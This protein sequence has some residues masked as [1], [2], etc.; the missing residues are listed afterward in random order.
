MPDSVTIGRALETG[1]DLALGDIERRSGLYVLGK[2]GM[3]K[4]TLLINLILK[5]IAH[6]HGVFFLGPHGD[7]VDDIL[8]RSD[9]PRV[10]TDVV[11]LDP[12]HATH[13][14]S[15]NLLACKDIA[16]WR[17]REDTYARARAVFWKL[18]ET[19][20]Q[21]TWLP[22]VLQNTLYAFIESPGYSLADVPEFLDNP[23]FRSRIL[24]NVQYNRVAADFFRKDFHPRQAQPLRDRLSLLLGHLPVRHIVGQ[25]TTTV[26]LAK[27]IEERKILLIKLSAQLPPDQKR[28]IGMILVSELLQAVRARGALPPAQRHQFSI[29]VDEFQNFVSSEDFAALINEGRKFAVA[30]TIAH[31]ERYGQ[32]ADNRALLGATATAANKVYFQLSGED[33][34]EV[35]L[36]FAKPPPTETRLEP[37]LV[38]SQN[39]ISELLRGHANPQIRGFVTRYLRPL[40]ERPEDIKADMEEQRLLRDDQRDLAAMDRVEAQM[41]ALR[42][43]GNP[44]P[45]LQRV[46]SA[47][48]FA[49]AQTAQLLSLQRSATELRSVTRGL[50]RFLTAIM[51]GSL[52]QGQEPFSD[53]LIGI[54]RV[55]EFSL[56]PPPS[57]EVLALYIAISYGHSK[58]PRAIPFAFA[59][60]YG[61]FQ[62]VAAQ[63]MEQAETQRQKKE[64]ER[65]KMFL[66]RWEEDKDVRASI[67]RS[68]V[69]DL[70]PKLM[71]YR[72][73]FDWWS[74]DLENV[75]LN[76]TLLPLSKPLIIL[77][78][79]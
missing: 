43:G 64:D 29:F 47:L 27:L 57:A 23:E 9:S 17:E 54:T 66:A 45:A 1:H 26:D 62:A 37:Q 46:M 78:F 38:I 32:L 40:Q 4:T 74:I 76:T 22:L 3:G 52:A 75:F 19:D 51:E 61:L 24:R 39:P 69:W 30:T 60:K 5:D 79:L 34:R 10:L 28:F 68:R 7:A 2:P 11:E 65:H 20:D 56:V 49:R 73:R 16:S 25:A 12:R 18:F 71:T 36:D 13:A 42:Y 44:Y 77:V 15:I 14:F 35:A 59:L 21:A 58:T 31:Q 55:R 48:L 6:G 41:E 67:R 50:N 53:F 33:A 70:W 72:P 8:R 63:M